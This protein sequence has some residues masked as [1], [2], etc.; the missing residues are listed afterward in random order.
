MAAQSKARRRQDAIQMNVMRFHRD[1]F[2]DL[3]IER[4]PAGRAAH[5][6]QQLV[7]KPLTPAKPTALQVKGYTRHQNQVQP[8]RW[9]CDAMPAR[10]ANAELPVVQV[11]GQI[12]NLAG[13]IALCGRVKTGQGDGLAGRQRIRDERPDVQFLRKRGVEED[14]AG[15]FPNRLLFQKHSS[16]V[17]RSVTL[18][19]GHRFEPGANFL[20]QYAF[21]FTDI[22]TGCALKSLALVPKGLLE[23]SPA[24]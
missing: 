2:D 18:L 23:N 16:L 21:G 4:D 13:D 11:F 19:Y 10:L 9:H 7:I 24:F 12:L 17:R 15:I 5:G 3:F 20:P 22:H 1:R 8:V 14:C 6:R